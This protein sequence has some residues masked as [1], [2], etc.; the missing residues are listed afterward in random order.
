MPFAGADDVNVRALLKLIAR[1]N[2]RLPQASAVDGY[3]R[4]SRINDRSTS[5]PLKYRKC[6]GR[7][8]PFADCGGEMIMHPQ[9]ESQSAT[10]R[11][12]TQRCRFAVLLGMSSRRL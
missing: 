9:T 11:K 7:A 6:S 3:S 1:L 5:A 12:C 10:N 8:H 2:T 4:V